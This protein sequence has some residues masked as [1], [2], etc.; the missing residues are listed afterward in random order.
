MGTD[1]NLQTNWFL[2]TP[3]NRQAKYHILRCA[4]LCLVGKTKQRG[5]FQL[6]HEAEQSAATGD[7][8]L[9]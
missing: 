4:A 2:A 5:A 1:F 7:N 3:F 9:G 6:L 8:S